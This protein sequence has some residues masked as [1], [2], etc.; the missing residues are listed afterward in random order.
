MIENA[1]FII[2]GAGS[3][4]CV[5]AERLSEDRRY[6]VLVIESGPKDT[7]PLID[8]PRGIGKLLT[9]SNPHVWSYEID[10]G[11]NHGPE[12]WLKGRTLGGSSAVNGMVYVRGF[13]TDYDRWSKAGCE[14]WAWDD[15]LPHFIANESHAFGANAWRGDSGLLKVT[16]HPV[17]GV[18]KPLGDAFLEAASE[19]GIPTVEDTNCHPEGGV[20]YQSRNIWK[21]RRQSAAKAFLLPAE[22]RHNVHVVTDTDVQRVLFEGRRAIGVEVIRGGQKSTVRANRDVIL[23]AGA[24]QSPKLLQLSGIGPGALLKTFDIDVVHDA[25]EVGRNL[26]EHLYLGSKFRCNSGSLNREFKSWRLLMNVVRYAVAHTGPLTHAAQ[27][28]IG[29][30]KTR[31]GLSRPDGQIGAGFYSVMNG[32]NGPELDAQPGFTIGGYHMH[33][34]SRGEMKIQSADPNAPPRIC[35]NYLQDPEDRAASVALFRVIRQIAQAPALRAFGVTELVP[36]PDIVS[37]DD[38]CHAFLEHGNTAF[39]VSGTCRMGSDAHAVVD[40][41]TRVRGVSNLRVVDTS[42]FPELPS[43]NTNAPAMAVARNAAQ[44]ILA[45]G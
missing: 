5:L 39:H 29:Y 22:R 28:I 42:I 37:D 33:P 14:G 44:M 36:G 30:V 16:G 2:V 3:S 1:D 26:C 6:K 19:V 17:R 12:T 41:K 38:I 35:A 9:P 43:G 40:P 15:M 21:G 24:I 10:K 7:S 4:G 20:G 34:R 23:A 32:E 25:P 31:P 18:S 45:E 8:M 13:P 27:E 11:G